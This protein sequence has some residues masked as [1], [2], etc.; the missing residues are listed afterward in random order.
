MFD[1]I[2][3]V[4]K[5]NIPIA[6][7]L[8]NQAVNNYKMTLNRITIHSILLSFRAD[9]YPN[10]PGLTLPKIS[11]QCIEDISS[12]LEALSIYLSLFKE[13]KIPR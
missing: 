10:A 11:I 3:Q 1:Y 6:A 13:E 12:I 5:F 7:V 8:A 2:N 4:K 9:F